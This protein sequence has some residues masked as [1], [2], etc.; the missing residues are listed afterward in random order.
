MHRTGP[1]LAT[2]SKFAQVALVI[3]LLGKIATYPVA[4]QAGI[5]PTDAI[6]TIDVPPGVEVINQAAGVGANEVGALY[7]VSM[8]IR[9][10]TVLAGIWTLLNVI[11]AG[12]GFITSSGNAQAHTKSRDQIVMSIL[13]LI[14]IVSV[15]TI[16]GV[17][18]LIFFGDAS[19]ILNPTIMGPTL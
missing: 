4:A 7:F 19:F 13:G 16:A 10:A 8:L 11:L 12:W 6:G 3:L 17:V 14:L 2:F 9:I 15:Y 5:P 1:L 18:G